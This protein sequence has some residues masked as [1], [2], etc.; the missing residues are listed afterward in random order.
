MESRIVYFTAGSL[1]AADIDAAQLIDLVDPET[2]TSARARGSAMYHSACVIVSGALNDAIPWPV[3]RQTPPIVQVANDL[4]NN[5]EAVTAFLGPLVASKVS[6][7]VYRFDGR[8]VVVA[9][10]ANTP[11]SAQFSAAL[12]FAESH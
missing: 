12:A 1:C 11:A 10:S 2:V 6:K 3:T 5:Q 7:R 8:K 4:L 9:T